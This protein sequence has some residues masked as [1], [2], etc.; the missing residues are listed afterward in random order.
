MPGCLPD[1]LT[2]F[3]ESASLT[4]HH[5]KRQMCAKPLSLEMFHF[6]LI[7]AC[8]PIPVCAEMYMHTQVRWPCQCIPIPSLPFIHIDEDTKLSYI[9]R[10]PSCIMLKFKPC[11]LPVSC[12]CS[13]WHH[14]RCIL[15]LVQYA[16]SQ[17]VRGLS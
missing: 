9:L 11:P 10:L 3:T 1:M 13:L 7:L 14:E 15:L 12:F 8:F 5:K 4:F 6:R 16:E 2:C 17:V